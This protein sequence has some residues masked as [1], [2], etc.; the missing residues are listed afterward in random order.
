[1]TLTCARCGSP[2]TPGCRDVPGADGF[3]SAEPRDDGSAR[4]LAFHYRA[5]CEGQRPA[6][7]ATVTL[8]PLRRVLAAPPSTPLPVTAA[9]TP[10]PHAYAV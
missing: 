3:I 6:P 5:D 4:I 8:E 10:V 2:T 1:M 9:E 7:R